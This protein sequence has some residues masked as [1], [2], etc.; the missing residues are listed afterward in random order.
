MSAVVAV[1][2]A[3]AAEAAARASGG[4]GGGEGERKRRRGEQ[5]AARECGSERARAISTGAAPFIPRARNYENAHGGA[6]KL[7]VVARA[8]AN[9]SL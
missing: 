5:A 7:P 6:R 1:A 4:G 8:R 2:A 9:Y 3:R